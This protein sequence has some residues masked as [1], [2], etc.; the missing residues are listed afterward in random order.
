MTEATAVWYIQNKQHISKQDKSRF[1]FYF[2]L[3]VFLIISSEMRLDCRRN[4]CVCDPASRSIVV[5]SSKLPEE[6]AELLLVNCSV[7]QL[8][9]TLLASDNRADEVEA[10]TVVPSRLVDTRFIPMPSSAVY[11]LSFFVILL[12]RQVVVALSD[13]TMVGVISLLS[14][15]L[16]ERF[17]FCLIVLNCTSYFF[18]EITQLVDRMA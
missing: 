9:D 17:S 18:Y 1:Q 13:G 2:D 14:S 15:L 3:P 12:S 5:K 7:T 16:F 10:S 11:T 6:H 4:G 8:G